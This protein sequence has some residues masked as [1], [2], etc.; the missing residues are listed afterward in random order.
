[1]NGME[2]A[3]VFV[4]G[5]RDGVDRFEKFLKSKF[6]VKNVNIKASFGRMLPEKFELTNFDVST[7]EKIENVIV[8]CEDFSYET[9]STGETIRDFLNGKAEVLVLHDSSLSTRKYLCKV[10]TLN[11]HRIFFGYMNDLPDGFDF[12]VNPNSGNFD[13]VVERILNNEERISM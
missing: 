10:E 7:F 11:I 5:M 4:G 3:I 1:M 12:N 8:E 13:E 9:L 6:Y 2:K